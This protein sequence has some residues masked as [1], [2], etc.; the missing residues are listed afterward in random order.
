[1]NLK[2]EKQYN[3][4]FE[5]SKNGDVAEYISFIIGILVAIDLSINENAY[6]KLPTWAKRHWKIRE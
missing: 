1:M 3:P 4:D 2:K 5:R 6:K